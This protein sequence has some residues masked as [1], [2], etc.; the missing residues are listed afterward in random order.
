MR[1]RSGIVPPAA[2][3]AQDPAQPHACDHPADDQ[4]QR[5]GTAGQPIAPSGGGDPRAAGGAPRDA[6]RA[7]GSGPRHAEH[8]ALD[9]VSAADRPGAGARL[10]SPSH[11][12]YDPLW[13][14]GDLHPGACGC[15]A[16]C[17][18][19]PGASCPTPGP[20]APSPPRSFRC[21]TGLS[22]SGRLAGRASRSLPGR[23]G[24]SQPEAV[25]GLDRWRRYLRLGYTVRLRAGDWVRAA[26]DQAVRADGRTECPSAWARQP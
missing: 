16:A 5:L 11:P 21:S 6:A 26:H 8:R 4:S 9:P 17:S 23:S 25:R 15:T 18:P 14:L 2:V 12:G 1:A 13:P 7:P 20:R 3:F 19:S 10:R 24:L 22:D